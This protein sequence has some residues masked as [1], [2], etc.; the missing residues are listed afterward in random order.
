ME[1]SALAC[2]GNI[3]VEPKKALQD[4]RPHGSW[5]WYPLI[6]TLILT[7]AWTTWYFSTVDMGWLSDQMLAQYSSKYSSDQL[8]MMRQG[9]TRSRFLMFGILAGSIG[10]I[11]ILL[12]QALYFFFVAKIGGYEEQSYGKWFSFS[13]WTSFPNVL[14]TIAA[15]IA[16]LFASHQTSWYSLDVTSLNTLLFHLPMGHPL[17]GVASSFHLTG[18]WALGLMIV[19]FSLWTKKSLGKSALIVLAPWVVIYALWIILKL[20]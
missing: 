4:I 5:A 7:I 18:F 11:V 17:M 20:V 19:G 15:G 10:L 1:T 14:A 6:I 13:I 3:F 9:F 2:L 12:L 8:D 16:Y